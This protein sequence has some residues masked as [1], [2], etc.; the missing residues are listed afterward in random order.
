MKKLSFLALLIFGIASTINA[1][2]GDVLVPTAVGAGIGGAVGGGRGAGIGAGIGFG[3]GLMNESSRNNGRYYQ[4]RHY[5]G[6]GD[7]RS[8]RS[9]GNYY[10][11]PVYQ[12]PYYDRDGN[13]RY[14][15]FDPRVID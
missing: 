8:R 14:L 6:Y 4:D 11:E 2:L 10:R 13:R 3:I 5:D 9:R 15:N 1:D 12:Q 7:Y